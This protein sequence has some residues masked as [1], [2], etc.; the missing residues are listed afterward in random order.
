M[1]TLD[2]FNDDAFSVTSLTDAINDVPEGQAVPSV[3]DA[4]FAPGT[5]GMRTT[6]AF[7]ERKADTLTLVPSAA[8]GAPGE[9]YKRD[10]A[11]VIPFV[12][13]HLPVTGGVEADEVLNA[14]AFGTENEIEV[15]EQ[16]VQGELDAMRANMQATI[17]FHRMGAIKGVVY[18][19]DGTSEL[20]NLFDAFGVAQNTH[21]MN[22][23]TDDL[24]VAAVSAKRKAEKV[25]G[26]SAMISG[27]TALCDEGF[28]DAM[29]A[30]ADFEKAFERW[31]DGENLRN[32]P[33]SGIKFA[34]VSWQ[35]LYGKVGTIE[36]IEENTAYLIPLG[37][38]DLFITRF[39]PANYME[40]VGTEG[41]PY[42]AKQELRRFGK[43]IDLEG[44]SNPL[45]LCT[46]PRAIIKLTVT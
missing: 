30:D 21:A 36:F 32:D 26:N 34:G 13:H 25:I 41:L 23:G 1:P 45:S 5:R 7:I 33:R 10:K 38:R 9:P 14:R 8:R 3:V 6:T 11:G 43:G 44:Q 35:E 20:L 17:T 15:V 42:Y 2:I 28:I 4:L 31:N 40:A 37:V 24:R 19:A 18:D 22:I 29:I 46:R 39:A 16:V 12:A 27:W